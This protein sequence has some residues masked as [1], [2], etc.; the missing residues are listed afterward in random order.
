MSCECGQPLPH[1]LADLGIPNFEHVCS[2]ERKY[3]VENKKFVLI[4]TEAN[5]FARYDEAHAS[6]SV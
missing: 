6:N 5:P 4:G 3:K 2:C 1:H